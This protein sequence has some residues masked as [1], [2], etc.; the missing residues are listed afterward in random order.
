MINKTMSINPVMKIYMV[1]VKKDTI[2]MKRF[3]KTGLPEIYQIQKECND[4]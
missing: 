4:D 1:K 2:N 3:I